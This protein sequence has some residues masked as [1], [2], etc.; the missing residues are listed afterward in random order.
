MMNTNQTS[1]Q[2]DLQTFCPKI[3]KYDINP[4]VAD[5]IKVCLMA[6]TAVIGTLGGTYKAGKDLFERS[7]L[8]KAEKKLPKWKNSSYKDV[9]KA[10][11]KQKAIGSK[12]YTALLG[13]AEGGI[14]AS[15][16][17]LLAKVCIL[18]NKEK[19]PIEGSK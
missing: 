14:I 6:P 7:T 8:V 17:Y 15:L 1:K 11:V 18:K 10:L 3:Q 13:F 5:T 4:H 12:I 9:E 2:S 16:S 19:P